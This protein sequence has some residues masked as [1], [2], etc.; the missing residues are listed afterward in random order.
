MK[1]IK[2]LS[3]TRTTHAE[4]AKVTQSYM[5]IITTHLANDPFL[6]AI[7]ALM[8]P[9]LANLREALAAIRINS[10]VKE[11]FGLDEIRDDAFV[12]FRDLIHAFRKSN[13]DGEIW[14]YHQ[15]WSVIEKVGITLYNKSYIEQS[16]RLETLFQEMDKA[17]NLIAM[18]TL[19]VTAR[20]ETLK[21]AEANFKTIYNGKLDEDA[22][23]NYP[24]I[25]GARAA[26]S[27]LVSDLFPTLRNVVRTSKEG[28][29]LDW[30]KLIDEQTEQV[31]IQIAARRTRKSNEEEDTSEDE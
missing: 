10:L 7:A 24:T 25:R 8:A 3:V 29:N 4:L 21:T 22:K 9:K 19:G 27:P 14:A 2:D 28:T 5:T 6:M 12:V 17:D 11:A 16:G 13:D 26:L 18:N 23:K 20:Y 31:M 30:A 1:E 15:L